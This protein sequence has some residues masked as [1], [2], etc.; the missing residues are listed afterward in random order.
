MPRPYFL[1]ATFIAAWC[2]CSPLWAVHSELVPDTVAAQHGLARPWFAQVELDQGRASNNSVL[3]YEGILYIQ[4]AT[5]MIHAVDAETGK[6]L[7]SKQIGM[8][9]H[10]NMPPDA[11]GDLLAT[12]SGSRLYI[13]NRFT[14]ALLCEKQLDEAP[15]AGPAI[16]SKRV[17]IPSITGLIISYRI[18]LPEKNSDKITPS[19]AAAKRAETK[20]IS[21]NSINL[22]KKI[23][24]V[25]CQSNGRALVQPLVTRDDVGG[26][27]LT[28]PTD[29]GFLNLGR[30]SH[31]DENSFGVKYRLET[32]ATIVTRPTYLP[33]DPKVIGDAGMVVAASCDGF[34][35]AIQEESGETLWRFSTGEPIVEPPAVIDDH[36]FV[37][38][39]LGTMYCLDRKT[40]NAVW[41]TEGA[42]RFV[43]AS[44]NRVFAADDNGRLVILN[45]ANGVKLDEMLIG[46]GIDILINSDTDRIYLISDGGLVQCLH[47]IEQTQPIL[48]NKERKDAAKAGLIAQ[49]EPKKEV[50]HEKQDRPKKDRE[51]PKAAPAKKKEKAAPTDFPTKKGKTTPTK[52]GKKA[53]ADD[54][55]FGDEPAPKGKAA[56]KTPKAKKGANGDNPF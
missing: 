8:P 43:S 24:A 40:G 55:G 36:V 20:A 25:L 10:P 50:V 12:I 17:Y 18:E 29:R 32:A 27:Y 47:E 51:A 28:W 11:K 3:L 6:S 49:P 41:Q 34:L 1:V 48:H 26:E 22:G 42:T 4:T 7:W 23:P 52:R 2:S 35:Y 37:A 39:Q 56:K 45:A 44:K 38:T 13:V 33:P 5:G 15:G 54:G 53:A 46:Q 31:E 16:S 30:V 21:P 14:G 9:K 19:V